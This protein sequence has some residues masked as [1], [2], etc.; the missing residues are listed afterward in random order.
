MKSEI[1]F[2]QARRKQEKGRAPNAQLMILKI[3]IQQDS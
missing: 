3:L 2:Y 1:M